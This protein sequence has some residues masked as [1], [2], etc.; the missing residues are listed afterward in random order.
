[1]RAMAVTD[2]AAPLEMLD[3]PV[4]DVAP[5]YVLVRI[6][7]CGVCYTDVKVARGRILHHPCHCLAL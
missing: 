5:G 6:L 2:Y 4:P 1:M 7:A 3:L